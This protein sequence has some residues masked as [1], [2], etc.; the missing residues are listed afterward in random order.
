MSTPEYVPNGDPQDNLARGIFCLADALNNVA[1]AHAALAR[2]HADL[3]FG[4]SSTPGIGEKL[5]MDLPEH[6]GAVTSVIEH[7]FDALAAALPDPSE[8]SG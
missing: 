4:D 5:Y 3:G 2:A 6:I 1:T 7:G 8:S